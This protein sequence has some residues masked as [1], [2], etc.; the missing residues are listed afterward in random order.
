MEPGAKVLLALSAYFMIQSSANLAG[1]ATAGVRVVMDEIKEDLVSQSAAKASKVT[2]R[3]DEGESRGHCAATEAALAARS[4]AAKYTM[5]MTQD[6][7][8]LVN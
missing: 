3:S 4:R 7:G 1:S 5:R 2:R 6:A 8:G